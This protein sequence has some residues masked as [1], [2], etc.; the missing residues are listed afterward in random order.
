MKWKS[1]RES[2][3]KYYLS[4]IKLEPEAAI[5]IQYIYREARKN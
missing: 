1:Y 4:E 3:M 5:L 2:Q